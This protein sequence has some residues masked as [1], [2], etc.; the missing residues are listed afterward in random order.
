[1]LAGRKLKGF[2]LVI[3][4]I[5]GNLEVHLSSRSKD[6]KT[7]SFKSIKRLSVWGNEKEI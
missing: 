1:M 4:V 3:S 5:I 2:P 6:N 7:R